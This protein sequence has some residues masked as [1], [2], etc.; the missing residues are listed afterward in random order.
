MEDDFTTDLEYEYRVI[1]PGD[2]ATIKSL[3]EEFFPVRYS[4]KFFRDA[5]VGIGFRGGELF[6]CLCVHKASQEV[7]G[8]LLAQLLPEHENEDPGLLG[9]S[10][11]ASLHSHSLVCYILTLG[12]KDA[13]RRTGLGSVLL[14]R[15]ITFAESNRH[16]GAVYLHVIHNN[17][18]AIAFYK[19][20]GFLHL[21]T[22]RGFYMIA[23]QQQTAF[24]LILYVN[25]YPPPLWYR[26]FT[27]WSRAVDGL[28]SFFGLSPAPPPPLSLPASASPPAAESA[29]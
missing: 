20:N 19:R 4:D 6:T 26:L 8:F 1:Q 9:S 14:Q 27:G 10:S 12:V 11:V 13:Q 25:S 16:C 28:L 15:C 24:L 18:S 22:L 5:C 3:H 21:R 23:G 2:Y 17:P 7:V 29:V